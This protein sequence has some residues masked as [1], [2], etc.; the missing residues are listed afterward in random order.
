[1]LWF[2]RLLLTLYLLTVLATGS[3]LAQPT[4]IPP[5]GLLV[6]KDPQTGYIEAFEYNAAGATNGHVTA[7]TLLGGQER[8]IENAAI[9]EDVRYPKSAAQPVSRPQVEGNLSTLDNLSRRYPQYATLFAASAARLR[10]LPMQPLA[11]DTPSAARSSM[12]AFSPAVGSTA[13]PSSAASP[14]SGAITSLSLR[15]GTRYQ[16]VTILHTDGDRFTIR[17]QKGIAEVLF[18]DLPADPKSLPP[19]VLTL[20]KAYQD[21]VAKAETERKRAQAAAI[22]RPTPDSSLRVASLENAYLDRSALATYFGPDGY[23]PRLGDDLEKVAERASTQIIHRPDHHYVTAWSANAILDGF[24]TFTAV[25]TGRNVEGIV[26]YSTKDSHDHDLTPMADQIRVALAPAAFE[27]SASDSLM[28]LWTTNDQRLVVCVRRF[29]GFALGGQIYGK[30][31]NVI[32]G[33][34]DAVK[35]INDKQ[36]F[37]R[38]P[39]AELRD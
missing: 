14:A 8:H 10:T 24:C 25:G 9:V 36:Y 34:A 1:M 35:L 12:P 37:R 38:Q 13:R 19:E 27:E 2:A 39:D 16:D 4:G 6:S 18:Q 22:Q 21:E 23:L 26:V 7:Y 15:N 33:D 32:F 31:S 5:L 3:L 17:H 20:L 11:A 28:D 29:A 30:S